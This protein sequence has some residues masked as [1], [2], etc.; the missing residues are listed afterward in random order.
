VTASNGDGV[1]KSRRRRCVGDGIISKKRFRGLNRLVQQSHDVFYSSPATPNLISTFHIRT[2]TS[3][4][5]MELNVG[6]SFLMS[7][8]LVITLAAV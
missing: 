3:Q 4:E 1:C 7:M 2:E 5:I 8:A 6:I